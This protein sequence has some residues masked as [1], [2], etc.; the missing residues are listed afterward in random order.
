MHSP[1]RSFLR[2]LLEA[3]TRRQGASFGRSCLLEEKL[4]GSL[5]SPDLFGL[6]R[7]GLPPVAPPPSHWPPLPKGTR[8]IAR[9]AKASP[10]ATRL[11][12]PLLRSLLPSSRRPSPLPTVAAAARCL[13]PAARPSGSA[14]T[15]FALA[16][17]GRQQRDAPANL[18]PGR[19][20]SFLATPPPRAPRV[21]LR[22]R[23][24]P[25][26]IGRCPIRRGGAL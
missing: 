1:P 6:V 22:G 3:R 16:P 21:A 8:G 26:S 2:S 5:R 24:S 14:V 4:L 13:A 7:R 12:C 11:S 17:Y 23:R 10:V 25:R 19:G 18:T 15:P 9:G 20:R